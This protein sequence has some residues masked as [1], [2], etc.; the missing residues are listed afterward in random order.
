MCQILLDWKFVFSLFHFSTVDVRPPHLGH[1]T[2][3]N[4]PLDQNG[5][6]WSF[7]FFFLCVLSC[8]ALRNKMPC[9]E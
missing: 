9:N 1:L 8:V 2:L 7:F 6:L 5:A 4:R 3:F